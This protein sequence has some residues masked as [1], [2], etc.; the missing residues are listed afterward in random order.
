MCVY[1]RKVLLISCLYLHIIYKISNVTEVKENRRC[2]TFRCNEN[3]KLFL[4]SLFDYKYL[5]ASLIIYII[6]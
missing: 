6:I 5:H 3:L 2:N 4:L 1:E